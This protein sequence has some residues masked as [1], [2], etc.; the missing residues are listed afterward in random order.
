MCVCVVGCLRMCVRVCVCVCACVLVCAR[1]CVRGG[2]D[3]E[4]S[5]ALRGL[6]GVQQQAV[7]SLTQQNAALGAERRQL[8]EALGQQGR[9]LLR[10]RDA[11]QDLQ[12]RLSRAATPSP[13]APGPPAP[14]GRGGESGSGGGSVCVRVGECV[15]VVSVCV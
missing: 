2:A 1:A 14:T 7:L 3:P 8:Q 10:G 9:E 6:L 13:A 11:I 4:P 12:A 5:E 15:C